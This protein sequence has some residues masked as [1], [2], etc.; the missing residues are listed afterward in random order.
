MNA[1]V[2]CGEVEDDRVLEEAGLLD[3]CVVDLDSRKCRSA[4]ATPAIAFVKRSTV[5]EIP[6]TIGMRRGCRCGR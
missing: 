3:A 2:S 6:H 4:F 1:P 5:A